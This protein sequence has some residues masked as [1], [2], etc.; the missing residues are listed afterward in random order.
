MPFGCSKDEDLFLLSDPVPDRVKATF[1]CARQGKAGKTVL[2]K[3]LDTITLS[4]SGG[5]DYTQHIHF[6]SPKKSCD[7]APDVWYIEPGCQNIVFD[8]EH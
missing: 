8:M 1:V 4:Q 5:A 2:P 3:S 7:Y 6:V